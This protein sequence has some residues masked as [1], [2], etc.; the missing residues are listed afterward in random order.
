MK[1]QNNHGRFSKRVIIAM[2]ILWFITAIYGMIIEG[3]LIFTA[4]E[5]IN[6]EPLFAFVGYPMTGGLVFYFCKS[7]F[8]NG[9]KIVNLSEAEE[10]DDYE[11][12]EGEPDDI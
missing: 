11:F 5:I 6:L 7:A 4:P 8:E 3:V 10:V 1:E 12:E 9:K 2:T